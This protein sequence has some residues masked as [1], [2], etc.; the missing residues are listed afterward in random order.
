MINNTIKG[1]SCPAKSDGTAHSCFACNEPIALGAQVLDYG[2][3]GYCHHPSCGAITMPAVASSGTRRTPDA[4]DHVAAAFF[5][6]RRGRVA[7]KTYEEVVQ[8][9]LSKLLEEGIQ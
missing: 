7:G 1:E 2:R 8:E 5:A 9:E 4:G 6:Q 3:H